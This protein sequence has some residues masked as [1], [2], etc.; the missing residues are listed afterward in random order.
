MANVFALLRLLPVSNR[1]KDTEILALRHQ[2][3]VLQRQ[4]GPGRLRFTP[5]DRALLAAL[6]HRLPRHV[7]KRLHLVV[8]PDTVLRWHRDMVARRHARRSRPRHPGPAAHRA[9]D[10]RP[11]AAAGSRAFPVGVTPGARGV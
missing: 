7:L 1:D 6:L 3:S 5:A 8:R 9:L 2:L 4:L 10:P 11:G